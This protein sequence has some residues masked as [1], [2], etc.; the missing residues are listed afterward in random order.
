[1]RGTQAEPR[2]GDRGDGPAAGRAHEV[3]G[4]ALLALLG[5][6]LEP[7]ERQVEV[8]GRADGELGPHER[9]SLTLQSDQSRCLRPE[10]RLIGR[11]TAARIASSEPTSTSRSWA[12]VIAVYSSSRVSRR[13]PGS[14]NSTAAVENCEPWL[15][16]TVIA[17]TVSTASSR[18]G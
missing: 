2:R 8:R 11:A 5:Q 9:A 4:E 7:D 17:N 14:G 18:P 1:E 3:A 13:E 16:C 10:A 6:R 12:R 15:L